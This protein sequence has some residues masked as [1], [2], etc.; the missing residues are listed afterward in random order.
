MNTA[1][2]AARKPAAAKPILSARRSFG[3]EWASRLPR[4]G[5]SVEGIYAALRSGYFALPARPDLAKM[6]V[7]KTTPEAFDALVARR[8]EEQV[9]DWGTTRAFARLSPGQ[10]RALVAATV[11]KE[12]ADLESD[13]L[14]AIDAATGVGW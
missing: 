10:V 12:T 2:T 7:R 9:A 5:A 6:A 11:V 8:V 13:A 14:R 4:S 3:W 1:T